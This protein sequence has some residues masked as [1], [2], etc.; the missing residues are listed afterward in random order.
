MWKAGK[1]FK[2]AVWKTKK[3]EWIWK[4]R[5]E[6]D[7]GEKEVNQCWKEEDETVMLRYK[8]N[9]YFPVFFCSLSLSSISIP[10]LLLLLEVSFLLLGLM[11]ICFICLVCFILSMH[12]NYSLFILIL[13]AAAYI[14]T[15]SIYLCNFCIKLGDILIKRWSEAMIEAP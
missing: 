15:V 2:E 1:M 9:Q 8:S 3:Q 12:L 5:K 14:K 6:I 11:A 4:G 13:T 10:F 7:L